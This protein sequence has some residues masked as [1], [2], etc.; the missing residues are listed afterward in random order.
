M[1]KRK[2]TNDTDELV[3]LQFDGAVSADVWINGE[4][5]GVM[6]GDIVEVPAD[7]VE[8]RLKKSYWRLPDEGKVTPEKDITKDKGDE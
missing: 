3:K 8:S 2:K 7:T 1:P 6:P 4:P 5:F